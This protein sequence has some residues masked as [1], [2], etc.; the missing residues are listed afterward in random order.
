LV[1][2]DEAGAAIDRWRLVQLAAQV[3]A[4]SA[5]AAAWATACSWR[6]SPATQWPSGVL[7]RD[8]LRRVR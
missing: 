4:F 7:C 5:K 3:D 6:A 1:K 8:R 2:R